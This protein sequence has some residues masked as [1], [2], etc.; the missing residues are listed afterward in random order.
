M[1]NSGKAAPSGAWYILPCLLLLT[2]ILLAGLGVA[3]FVHFIESDFRAVQPGA[4]ISATM[5]GFTLYTDA[6]AGAMR[7]ADLRC[8]ATGPEG[9]VQLQRVIGRT[10][11]GN[12]QSSFVALASTPAN[13]PAGRYV[14]SCVSAT[15][16]VE[17][18]LYLGPRFDV[19]AVGRLVAFNIVA[20][21]FLGLCGL[22]LF[23]VIAVMRFRR[24]PVVT[25]PAQAPP[26]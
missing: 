5:D 6:E 17:L 24:R 2:A 20:P 13:L 12:G 19:P 26:S 16:R 9:T 7:P 18:P 8:T 14:I 11:V 15:D 4:P 3:S 25:A 1:G 10:T 23:V 21:L 22:V